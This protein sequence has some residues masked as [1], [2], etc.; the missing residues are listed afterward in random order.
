MS[1][2][3]KDGVV[4]P[5]SGISISKEPGLLRNVGVPLKEILAEGDISPENGEG[6]EEHSHQVVVFH[7]EETLEM[8]GTN[9]A[10]GNENEKGHGGLGRTGEKVDTP[11]R[12]VP[13]MIEGHQ[14][15]ESCKGEAKD[16]QR[17]DP[18]GRMTQAEGNA[19][20]PILVLTD[21]EP[22]LK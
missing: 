7:G 15:V 2:N 1:N 20:I 3:Q 14:P 6:K 17:N 5:S 16:E 10:V 18:V 12:R 13:V 8:T 11:H 21:R 22:A 4:E 9:E 19:G